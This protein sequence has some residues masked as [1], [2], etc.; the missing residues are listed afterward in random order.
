MTMDQG[1]PGLS[2]SDLEAEIDEINVGLTEEMMFN[3][4]CR[5][6]K[7]LSEY[8]KIDSTSITGFPF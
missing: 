3:K 1:L 7:I 6:N 2:R 8:K 4:K 5:G